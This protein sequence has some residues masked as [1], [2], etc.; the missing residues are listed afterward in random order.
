MQAFLELFEWQAMFHPVLRKKGVALPFEK[1][2][3][4]SVSAV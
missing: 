4:M 3:Q 1:S 2:S